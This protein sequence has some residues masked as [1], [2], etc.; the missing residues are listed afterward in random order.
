MFAALAVVRRVRSP[1]GPPMPGPARA[2][3]A[4]VSLSRALV[5]PEQVTR[6]EVVK[7]DTCRRCG[8]ALE[9]DDPDPY[10]HQAIDVPKVAR[11]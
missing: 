5:P 7:P 2:N 9:G 10:R 8:G 11:S 1:P 3:I 4:S 6:T